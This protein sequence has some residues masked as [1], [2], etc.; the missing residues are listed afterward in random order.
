MIPWKPLFFL[1]TPTPYL[2]VAALGCAMSDDFYS[3]P[4]SAWEKA[5]SLVVGYIDE[6]EQ[7]EQEE[8]KEAHQEETAVALALGKKLRIS[9]TGKSLLLPSR[10]GSLGGDPLVRLEYIRF[11]KSDP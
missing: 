6:E 11:R 10:K 5:R 8:G 3:F 7:E 9:V 1:P 2:F 4:K